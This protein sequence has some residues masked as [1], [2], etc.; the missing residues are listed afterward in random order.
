MLFSNR[1]RKSEYVRIRVGI[2]LNEEATHSALLWFL[3]EEEAL[4]LLIISILQ[5]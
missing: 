5:Y 3:G 4:L 1:F 2:A